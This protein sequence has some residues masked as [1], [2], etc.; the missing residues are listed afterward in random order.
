[1]AKFAEFQRGREFEYCIQVWEKNTAFIT[2]H[3]SFNWKNSLIGEE[4]NIH[5][6]KRI[7]QQ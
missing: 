3:Q 1:M 5:L 2:V 4:K 6:F 7:V